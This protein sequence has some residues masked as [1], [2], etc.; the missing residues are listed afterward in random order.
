M[1]FLRNLDKT[2]KLFV[3]WAFL[4]QVVLIVHFAIRKRLFES[5]TLRYGWIVYALAIPAVIISLVILKAGKPWYFWLA[6]FLFLA[7]AIFGYWIDY[8]KQIEWRAPIY[9]PVM[10]PYIV[11]YLGSIMFY[12]WP[13]MRLHKGLW[14]AYT[15]LYVISTI[16]NI[17]S[18]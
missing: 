1:E 2:D 3:V 10:V 5:Y 18:H 17:T 8:V 15:V 4:L 14:A 13:L 11:L 9:V 12:W 6:G 7:F 16:L